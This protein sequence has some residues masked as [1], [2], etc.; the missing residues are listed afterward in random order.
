V[1][2]EC[3]SFDASCNKLLSV[4]LNLP[5]DVITF[6]ETKEKFDSLATED[7]HLQL[8]ALIEQAQSNMLSDLGVTVRRGF[9]RGETG[10]THPTFETMVQYDLSKPVYAASRTFGAYRKLFKDLY[11]G[12]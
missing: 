6:A 3:A 8:E 7:Q 1:M 2:R 12:M 11:R 10:D 4:F 9:I 5:L